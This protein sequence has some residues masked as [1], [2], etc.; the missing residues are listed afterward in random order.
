MI[1]VTPLIAELRRQYPAARIAVICSL[2]NELIVRYNQQ[3]DERLAI[4]FHS[5]AGVLKAIVFLRNRRFD[6]I[7]DCTPGFST[8]NRW[9]IALGGRGKRS[10]GWTEPG[11]RAFHTVAALQPD[12]HMVDYYLAL[13]KTALGMTIPHDPRPTIVASSEHEQAAQQFLSRNPSRGVMVG[14]NLSAGSVARQWPLEQYR[15]LV[16]RLSSDPR[17]SVLLFGAGRQREWKAILADAFPPCIAAPDADILVM[18]ELIRRL[19]LLISPD[20]SLIH[21]ASAWNIPVVGLYGEDNEN[22]RRWQPYRVPSRILFSHSPLNLDTIEPAVVHHNTLELLRQVGL[23]GIVR[24][25]S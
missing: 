15:D 1:V 14:V 3:V 19:N 4:N 16:E 8:T 18:S 9:I 12:R 22:F 5:P 24:L 11:R 13:S 20:T 21:I 25:E 6:F 23:P 10:V 17:M 7:I 2:A